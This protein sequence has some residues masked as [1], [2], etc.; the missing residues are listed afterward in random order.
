MNVG[1]VI[2]WSVVSGWPFWCDWG[3]CSHLIRYKGCCHSVM[4]RGLVPSM[5][6]MS[7][8]PFWY[9]CR[10]GFYMIRYK[11]Y[12][13][14]W[15]GASWWGTR[16]TWSRTEGHS[17]MT[18]GC[19]P[20]W[21]DVSEWTFWCDWAMCSHLIRYKGYFH[22]WNGATWWGT[23]NPQIGVESLSIM[24]AGCVPAWLNV[25]VGPFWC[26]YRIGSYMIRCK[27]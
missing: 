5:S 10:I 3:M 12:C 9:D 25:S 20:T 13:H 18:V 24:V 14:S 7:A 8:D 23:R 22:S 15:N 1:C 17:S 4:V 6:D 2:T 27:C 21:L 16:N 11:G 26:N 19:V